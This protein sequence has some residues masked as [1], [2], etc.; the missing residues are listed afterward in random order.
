[1]LTIAYSQK[2][3]SIVTECISDR[4]DTTVNIVIVW[5]KELIG[6]RNVVKLKWVKYKILDEWF[7][8][9]SKMILKDIS[10]SLKNTNREKAPQNYTPALAKNMNM[11]IWVIGTSN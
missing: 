11:D 6:T 1:M 10:F 8:H 5:I 2:S 4:N 9:M 7:S 3:V